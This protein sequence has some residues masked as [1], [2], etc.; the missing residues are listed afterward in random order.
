[1]R[2]SILR[3]ALHAVCAAVFLVPV[4]SIAKE[5]EPK[6]TIIKVTLGSD[7]DNKHRYHPDKLTFKAGQLYNLTLVNVSN[8]I[9]EIDSSE[10]TAAVFSKNVVVF[11]DI[12]EDAKPIATVVG[13]IAEIEIYPGGKT[14]WTFVAIEP[15]EY[16]VDCKTEDAKAGKTHMQMGMKATYTIE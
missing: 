5:N 4:T 7:T 2:T 8:N 11:D 13:K 16:E 9:H 10:F 3:S 15:G 12:A 1:M 14:E 6:P